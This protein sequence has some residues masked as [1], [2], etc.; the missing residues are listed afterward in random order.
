MRKIRY[1]VCTNKPLL[2]KLIFKL[3]QVFLKKEKYLFLGNDSF[4]TFEE[5]LMH[6]VQN[7]V[8]FIL[9]GGNLFHDT[10]PSQNTLQK[11]DYF[12]L[13]LFV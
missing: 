2:A 3:A 8:D 5:V 13:L 6:A 9:L 4:T 7:D 11:Y 1:E 12:N 10:N